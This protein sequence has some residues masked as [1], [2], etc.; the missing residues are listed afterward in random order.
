MGVGSS[1]TTDL[2][3]ASEAGGVA[4][5]TAC[6]YISGEISFQQ[7]DNLDIYQIS[8]FKN[9]D[10]TKILLGKFS[11]TK[12]I[13]L[14][15]Q[16]K[17]KGF[18]KFFNNSNFYTYCEN[19]YF[20]P[21]KIPLTIPIFKKNINKWNNG[22]NIFTSIA[23]S[24]IIKISNKFKC[25]SEEQII[26]NLYNLM[27]KKLGFTTND[28]DYFNKD[29]YYINYLL[30]NNLYN[31]TKYVNPLLYN[32]TLLC[33]QIAAVVIFS[34]NLIE[35]LAIKYN[36]I[37]NQKFNLTFYSCIFKFLNGR[38]KPI[39]AEEFNTFFDKYT[40]DFVP[41]IFNK[42]IINLSKEIYES[43]D[44]IKIIILK[45]SSYVLSLDELLIDYNLVFNKISYTE[46]KIRYLECLNFKKIYRKLNIN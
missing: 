9:D 10:L 7:I 41:F 15:S 39:L 34:W 19:G 4:G 45:Q 2:G 31:E 3:Y 28:F 26:L 18:D 12:G 46:V 16:D 21:T 40:I 13:I 5:E 23:S 29:F 35:K 33:I 6:D 14:T 32:I 30:E 38:E 36:I 44:I 25:I 20:Y 11:S 43:N 37:I 42:V 17:I 1:T 22:I 8:D 24:Y 27:Y